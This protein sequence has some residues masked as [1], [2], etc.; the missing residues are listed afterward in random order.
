[1]LTAERIIKLYNMKPLPEEGGYYIETYRSME[2]IDKACIPERFGEERCF[3]TAIFYLLT[4]DQKSYL[5]RLKSDEIYHFYLGDP[6]TML[7]LHPDGTSRLITLGQCIGSGENL[8]VV[9][10][11]GAWFGAFLNPGGRF[12]LM[13]TTMAPGFELSD[14]EHGRREVLLSQFPDQA[15]MI[16]K[17]TTG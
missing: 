14:Y 15:E 1:M 4:P 11:R 3:S 8:Q 9:V 16:L 6:V 7:Q 13:G 12:A 17:L 2:G 10:P 5:H